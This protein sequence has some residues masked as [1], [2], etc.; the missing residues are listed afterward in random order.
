[1]VANVSL[2]PSQLSLAVFFE[3]IVH[4]HELETQA[5]TALLQTTNENSAWAQTLR[6]RQAAGKLLAGSLE[7]LEQFD[8]VFS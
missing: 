6:T 2:P 7:F 4:L 5:T 1:M 8:E 3:F